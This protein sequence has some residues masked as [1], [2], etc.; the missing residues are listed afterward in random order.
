[1]PKRPLLIAFDVMGTLF[2]LEPLR[3]RMDTAG[4][5]PRSLQ[6]FFAQTLRDALALETSGT[7][8]TFAEVAAASLDVVATN[9]GVRLENVRAVDV[10]AGLAELPAHPD[11][12]PALERAR[13]AAVPV[14]TL[15]NGSAANTRVLLSQAGVAD[16]VERNV[17][18][19]E[20]G[21]WKPHREVYLRAAE[22]MGVEPGR[23]ALVAAHAWDTHGAKQAGLVS[24]W[25]QR[26]D[27]RYSAA[28]AVPDVRGGTLFDV[29]DGLLALPET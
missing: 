8:M 12:R 15:T 3:A 13:A 2:S 21:H 22:T 17:S 7:F 19:D 28:M 25:V 6:V 11:V 26:E 4:L 1:M 18:I 20:I 29:V 5:P 16:L 9:Y 10:L 14:I 24:G 27:V 23:T